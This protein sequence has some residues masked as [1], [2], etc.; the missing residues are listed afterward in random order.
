MIFSDHG[1]VDVAYEGDKFKFTHAQNLDILRAELKE[2]MK[3]QTAEGWSENR[4]MRYIGTIPAAAIEARPE[5]RAALNSGDDAAIR[6]A[7]EIYFNG[8]GREFMMNKIDSGKDPR[9]V[10]K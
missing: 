7:V 9:I 3:Y 1:L 10:V 5:L 6:K 2:R 4:S 8:E